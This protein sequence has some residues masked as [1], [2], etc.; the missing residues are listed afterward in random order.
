MDIAFPLVKSKRK[1][2]IV[3]IKYVSCSEEELIEDRYLL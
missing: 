2:V 3:E 1:E